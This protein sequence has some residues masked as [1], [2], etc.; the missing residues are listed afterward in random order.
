MIVRYKPDVKL[1]EGR[2]LY[3][4]LQDTNNPYCT[5]I[6]K[7]LWSLLDE[8]EDHQ[9]I[10]SLLKK[11]DGLLP[12]LFSDVVIEELNSRDREV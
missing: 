6:I 3:E 9:K 7:T 10:V 1:D 11:F 12:R 4:V 2:R 8:Q 5:D